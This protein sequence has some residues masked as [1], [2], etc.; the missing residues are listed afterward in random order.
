MTNVCNYLINY[1]NEL[2]ICVLL[3]MCNYKFDWH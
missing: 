1:F 3:L 2:L